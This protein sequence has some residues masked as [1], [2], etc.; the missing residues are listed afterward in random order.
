ME[1]EP[2]QTAVSSMAMPGYQGHEDDDVNELTEEIEKNIYHSISEPQEQPEA[3]MW[4]QNQLDEQQQQQTTTTAQ[5]DGIT[6]YASASCSATHIAQEDTP[7]HWDN[8][9]EETGDDNRMFE[10]A[11]QQQQPVKLE[12][13]GKTAELKPPKRPL[14][15]FFYF[16][17]ERRPQIQKEH[18][19]MSLKVFSFLLFW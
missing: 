10:T 2:P 11:D 17:G 7:H 16:S 15:A 8:F 13:E 3:L 4:E 1:H 5:E 19:G 6:L 12:G 9:Q 14:S 18:P